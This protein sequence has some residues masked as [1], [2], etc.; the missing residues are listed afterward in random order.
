MTESSEISN[1][2]MP[3]VLTHVVYLPANKI[4][5]N[6]DEVMLN[7]LKREVGNKCITFGYIDRD[8][9]SILQRSIGKINSSHLNG[10]ISCDVSYQANLC[11]PDEG[12]IVEC[13][14]KS[15]NKMGILAEVHPLTVV[16][17]RQHHLED[18]HFEMVEVGDCIQVKIMGKRFELNDDQITAIGQLVVPS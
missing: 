16:L 12:S 13:T 5:S 10:S 15:I 11:N 9:I 3:S 4:G 18:P 8:S 17:A 1:I 14:V 7:M 2:F 6:L